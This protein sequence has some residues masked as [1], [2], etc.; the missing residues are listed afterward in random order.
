[1]CPV[2]VFLEANHKARFTHTQFLIGPS[3]RQMTTNNTHYDSLLEPNAAYKMV[4]RGEACE[5][6]RCRVWRE[7]IGSETDMAEAKDEERRSREAEGKSE[8]S[9]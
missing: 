3:P 8:C 2:A 6:E 9:L 4:P 7:G 1:M 5:D